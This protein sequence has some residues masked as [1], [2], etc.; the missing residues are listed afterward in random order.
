MLQ[1]LKHERRLTENLSDALK[2]HGLHSKVEEARL[3]HPGYSKQDVLED[4]AED[5]ADKA[6]QAVDIDSTVVDPAVDS[7]AETAELKVSEADKVL[8]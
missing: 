1:E 7:A 8:V 4:G 5:Q 3:Q 2:E 6:E